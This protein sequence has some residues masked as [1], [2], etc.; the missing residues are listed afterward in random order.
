MPD[1]QALPHLPNADLYRASNVRSLLSARMVREGELI[2]TL[3]LGTIGEVRSFSTE[4][5]ALLRALAAQAAQAI[6]HA[7]LFQ[8]LQRELVER[9]QAAAERAQLLQ[10]LQA[11]SRQLL[12]AQEN[13]CRLARELHDEIGQSFTAV[14]INLQALQ[15]LPALLPDAQQLRESI[16]LV[17]RALQQTRN[18]SLDLRPLL[19]DDLGLWSALRWYVDRFGQQT[20]ITAHFIGAPLKRRPPEHVEITRFR[21]VQEALTN[22]ARHAHASHV[23]VEL[24]EQGN[25]LQLVIQDDGIGFDPQTAQTRARRGE[26][27]GLL[28]LEERVTLADGQFAIRSH[29]GRGTEIHVQFPLTPSR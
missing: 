3:T 20:G 5:L 15:H 17:E 14:K 12:Q 1:V 28:S 21:A 8:V 13:E 26:S 19:L 10:Q 27:L 23:R 22:I 24:R 4:E 11:L 29:S 7:R 6:A 16:G 18:L 9:Q 25:Q 2:G